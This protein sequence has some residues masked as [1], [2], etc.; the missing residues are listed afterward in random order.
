[1]RALPFSLG[2]ETGPFPL[3][4]FGRDPNLAELADLPLGWINL[5]FASFA[6]ICT[7]RFL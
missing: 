5:Q 7:C 1:M 2:C 4:R 3:V 6:E